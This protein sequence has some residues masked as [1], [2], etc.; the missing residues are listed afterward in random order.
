MFKTTIIINENKKLLKVI[1]FY[2]KL[3][4]EQ[5]KNQS[6]IVTGNVNNSEYE[7]ILGEKGIEKIDSKIVAASITLPKEIDI[8][9]GKL[10]DFLG[11]I[12]PQQK[13]RKRIEQHIKSI[14]NLC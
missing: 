11:S 12:I 10:S 1:T 14:A 3:N 7:I 13:I 6:M 4:N 9:H 8:T 2:L 5:L